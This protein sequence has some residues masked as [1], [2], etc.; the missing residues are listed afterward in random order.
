MAKILYIKT[1]LQYIQIYDSVLLL[2]LVTELNLGCWLHPH[3][4]KPN[5]HLSDNFNQICLIQVNL[6]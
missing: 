5:L 1:I 4:L 2:T 6:I 3:C